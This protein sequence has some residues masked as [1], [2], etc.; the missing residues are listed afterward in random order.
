MYAHIDGTVTEKSADGLV[1]DAGGVGY[2]LTVSASTLSQAPEVGGRMKVYTYLSVREDAMEL[3]GFYSREEKRMFE[4]LRAVGGVG[5]KSAMQILSTLSVSELALAL[6]TGDVAAISRAPGVGKKIAQRLILELRD[7]VSNE[8][9]IGRSAPVAPVPS[10]SGIEGEAI[11]ALMALGYQASEAAKAIA[12][13][14]PAPDRVDEL[15][16]L[17]L[18]GMMK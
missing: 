2:F 5:H 11:E 3:F 17:A 13:V 9:L 12:A 16:R 7:K 6:A 8:E 4:K 18:R 1:I 10:S 15:V 14:Q